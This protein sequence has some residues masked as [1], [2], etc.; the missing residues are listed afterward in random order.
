MHPCGKV[1]GQGRFPYALL[2]LNEWCP[3]HLAR[4]DFRRVSLVGVAG[5]ALLSACNGVMA[6]PAEAQLTASPAREPPRAPARPADR[7]SVRRS[8]SSAGRRLSRVELKRSIQRLIGADAPVDITI[9]PDD[10]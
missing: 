3:Q 5:L 7:I 1:V 8:R 6:R 9:L 4:L 2:V 10:R